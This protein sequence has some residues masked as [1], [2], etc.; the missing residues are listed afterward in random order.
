MADGVDDRVDVV[1]AQCC[2]LFGRGQLGREREVVHGPAKG[3][4]HDFHRGPLTRARIADVHA[5][6]A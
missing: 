4:E 1:V 6:A 5:H 2:G 3:I